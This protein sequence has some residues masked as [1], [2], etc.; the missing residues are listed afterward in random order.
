VGEP[1][2]YQPAGMTYSPSLK[3]FFI[4]HNDCMDKVLPD[5]VM[6]AGFDGG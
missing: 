3:S 1:L 4:W 6:T 5:A 2:P